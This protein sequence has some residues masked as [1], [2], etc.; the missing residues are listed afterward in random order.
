[1]K[2]PLIVNQN[3]A[4]DDG[5]AVATIDKAYHLKRGAIAFFDQAGTLIPDTVSSAAQITG[6]V[7]NA[8]VGVGNGKVININDI[9][10]DT[11]RYNYNAYRPAALKRMTIGGDGTNYSLNLPSTINPGDV[12]ILHVYN[13]TQLNDTQTYREYIRPI[14]VGA[15]AADIVNAMIDAVNSDVDAIAVAT[16]S[17]TDA[18]IVFT[19]KKDDF[20]VTSGG[21]LAN[22]DVLE[23]N[24][25]NHKFVAYTTAANV[26]KYDVGAGTPEQLKAAESYFF[27]T[28][29]DGNYQNDAES[30]LYTE[31]RLAI[32]TI[33]YDQ[34]NCTY[35][36]DAY[37][38]KKSDDYINNLTIYFDT[39]LTAL[40]TALDAI[41]G[42]I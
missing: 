19:A 39:T 2:T 17:A 36:L 25:V 32:P 28:R 23:Y 29:G 14:A 15:S 11:F 18:G 24:K 26:A 31:D 22:A 7:V 1:M 42:A 4:A 10:R 6:S 12:A 16:A 9:T 41:L 5:V 20:M 30:E 38:L 3:Y 33:S 13:T 40:K 21:V 8:I 37:P 27:A 35:Y 34:Y